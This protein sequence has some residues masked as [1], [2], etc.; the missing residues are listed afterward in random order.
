MKVKIFLISVCLFCTCTVLAQNKLFEKYAN[1]DDVTSIYISK[2]MFQMIS[3]LSKT[4]KGINFADM[5]NKIESLQ[6]IT[7]EKR[8]KIKQM[9]KE[10]AQLVSKQY[11][12]LMRITDNEEDIKF[13]ADMQESKIKELIL[14]SEEKDSF[15]V[16]RLVGNIDLQDVLNFKK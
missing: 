2:A 10:F 9:Q 4:T 6:I 11:Q 14:L 8:D 12:E 1:M 5:E 13:Y 7:C 16:I 15:T 3:D